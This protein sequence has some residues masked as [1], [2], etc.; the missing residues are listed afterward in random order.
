MAE[1]LPEASASA[2]SI[3]AW[4]TAKPRWPASASQLQVTV[5]GAVMPQR[6]EAKPGPA[7][8]RRPLSRITRSQAGNGA[9]RSTSEVT[10]A[11]I[12]SA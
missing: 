4:A 8:T 6:A 7:Q 5:C 12:N 2:S 3:K 11:A 1:S 10:P 9:E